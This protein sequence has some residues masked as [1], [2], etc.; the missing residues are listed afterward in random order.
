[1]VEVAQA[2]VEYSIRGFCGTFNARVD[3][4]NRGRGVFW[5]SFGM[6]DE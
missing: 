5:I 2:M 4:W 3:E 6:V 1:M